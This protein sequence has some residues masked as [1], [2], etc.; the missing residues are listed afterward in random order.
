MKKSIAIIGIGRFGFSLVKTLSTLKADVLTIDKNEEALKKVTEYATKEAIADASKIESLRDLG[1]QNYSTAVVAIGND[2][3]AT[4]MATINLVELGVP[5]IIV[6]VDDDEYIPVMNK[7]G[8]SRVIVPEE[9]SA[10]SFAHQLV[11]TNFADYYDIQGDYGIVKLRVPSY[12]KATP[13]IDI[14]ARNQF[15]VNIVGIIRNGKFFIPRG[16]DSINPN[17]QLLSIGTHENLNKFSSFLTN[18]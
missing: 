1:L 9:S 5:D 10:V 3:H 8:A 12:Y 17:D 7:L 2:I 14:D 11:S 18:E 13:L 4:I 6:R 15:A 16:T